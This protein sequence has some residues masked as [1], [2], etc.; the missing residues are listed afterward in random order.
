MRRCA[1]RPWRRLQGWGVREN[2]PRRAPTLDARTARRPSLRG[3]S[4]GCATRRV[5]RRAD[6]TRR[7]SVHG[8]SASVLLRQI[9]DQS[10]RRVAKPLILVLFVLLNVHLGLF[11]LSG[12]LAKAFCLA[13]APLMYHIGVFVQSHFT[14]LFSALSKVPILGLTRDLTELLDRHRPAEV[15]LSTLP[16]EERVQEFRLAAEHA[17]AKLTLSPYARAFVPL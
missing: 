1:R 6:H 10:G 3:K 14:G 15:V 7:N 11:L 16:D 8:G 13:A 2:S 5:G 17:G 12:A 4:F 9:F